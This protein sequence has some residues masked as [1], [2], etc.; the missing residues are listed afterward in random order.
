[1]QSAGL[2]TTNSAGFSMSKPLSAGSVPPNP[3]LLGPCEAPV[4]DSA[5]REPDV[6]A[7]AHGT[8]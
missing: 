2:A 8:F 7:A 6:E 4:K 3:I 1:M 5:T